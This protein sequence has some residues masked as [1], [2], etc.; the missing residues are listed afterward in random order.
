MNG[1]TGGC[2]DHKVKG[3]LKMCLWSEGFQRVRLEREQEKQAPE[4]N[5]GHVPH[6]PGRQLTIPHQLAARAAWLHL[7]PA[8]RPWAIRGPCDWL[9]QSRWA[10]SFC[11]QRQ[12]GDVPGMLTLLCLLLEPKSLVTV[13]TTGTGPDTELPWVLLGRE[14]GPVSHGWKHK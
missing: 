5:L 4:R 14:E 9:F 11:H 2:R 8:A 12:A 13:N 10:K 3:R 1:W 6:L 7:C